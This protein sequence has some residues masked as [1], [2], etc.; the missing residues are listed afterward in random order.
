MPPRRVAGRRPAP[1]CHRA[2]PTGR[3]PVGR[4][5]RAAGL[6]RATVDRR[7]AGHGRFRRVARRSLGSGGTAPRRGRRSRCAEVD[8]NGV[9]GVPRVPRRGRVDGGRDH[10]VGPHG[11]GRHEDDRTRPAALRRIHPVGNRVAGRRVG[12]RPVAVR[13]GHPDH[14]VRLNLDHDRSTAAP[15]DPTVDRAN[16]RCRDA[17]HEAGRRGRMADPT[18]TRD[19]HPARAGRDRSSGSVGRPGADGTGRRGPDQ[20][21]GRGR[22]RGRD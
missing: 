13:R 7:Q 10:P 3:R 12:T 16:H 6:G 1:R 9:P 21:R 11:R 15:A 8:P 4:R 14:Q 2:G 22:G 17:R 19:P 20:G 5:R 18:G